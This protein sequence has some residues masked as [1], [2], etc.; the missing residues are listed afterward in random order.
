[1]EM[2]ALL[3]S[4]SMLLIDETMELA[5]FSIGDAT[6]LSING[7]V[8]ALYGLNGSGKTRVLRAVEAA[9]LGRHLD[10]TALAVREEQGP[11]S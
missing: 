7:Q 8:T 4:G 9:L 5:G 6:H 10:Q 3:R 2:L 1:M 11:P